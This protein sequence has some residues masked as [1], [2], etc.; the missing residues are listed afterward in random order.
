M[1]ATYTYN[2]AIDDAI[3]MVAEL[4]DA[5]DPN[6][7][8]ALLYVKIVKGLAGLKRRT[9]RKRK[10]VDEQLGRTDDTNHQS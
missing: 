5:N 7:K 10:A 3:R 2:D 8:T 1:P 4:V 9:R 6:E